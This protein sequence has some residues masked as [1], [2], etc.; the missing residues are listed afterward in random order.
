MCLNSSLFHNVHVILTLMTH[1]IPL[2]MLRG[3]GYLDLHM[4]WLNHVWC[5]TV[6]TFILWPHCCN[7]HCNRA[8]AEEEEAKWRGWSWGGWTPEELLYSRVTADIWGLK[9]RTFKF[10][11]LLLCVMCSRDGL[12][13][14][15][16]SLFTRALKLI[17]LII[18]ILVSL[19]H[20]SHLN[21]F[22]LWR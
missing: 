2:D 13:V 1:N 12:W 20:I 21:V 6:T 9:Q 15:L 8:I 17:Q 11:S 22:T 18:F 3:W 19:N 4:H 14:H 16:C 10:P 7:R 5:D